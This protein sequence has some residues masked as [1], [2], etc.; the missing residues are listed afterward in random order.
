MGAAGRGQSRC[1]VSHIAARWRLCW[2][3]AARSGLVQVMP[4]RCERAS[5]WF[6]ALALRCELSSGRPGQRRIIA[7]LR[8]PITPISRGA[9]RYS[10][11]SAETPQE[12][13]AGLRLRRGV[14]DVKCHSNTLVAHYA[15]LT[16]PP[17]H[18]PAA[19]PASCVR[20]TPSARR[21]APSAK[22]GVRNAG[23]ARSA[24]EKFKK[25]CP[26]RRPRPTGPDKEFSRQVRNPVFLLVSLYCTGPGYM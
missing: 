12:V 15:R 18:W 25:V 1:L 3:R 22:F 7:S 24:G 19:W 6:R 10:C 21:W 26:V 4:G 14:F 23:P 9:V 16:H 17:Q 5:R 11:A 2:A 13:S 20:A 8:A